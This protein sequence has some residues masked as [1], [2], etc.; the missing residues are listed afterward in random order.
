MS[1]IEH[2]PL[3]VSGYTKQTESKI[4][5]VNHNKVVEEN[6]LRMLD[7]LAEMEEIDKRWLAIGRTHIEEGFMCINRSIFKPTRINP[8][9]DKDNG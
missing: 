2:T 9:K 5:M 1:D 4:E 8:H 3:P 7:K 6:I